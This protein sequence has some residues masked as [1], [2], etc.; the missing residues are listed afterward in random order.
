MAVIVTA[1]VASTPDVVMAN[2][3]V[4]APAAIVIEAGTTALVELDVSVTRAPPAGAGPFRVTVPVGEFPPTKVVGLVVTLAMPEGFTVSVAVADL[5]T[6]VP[7]R[8]T[9]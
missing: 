9:V 5:L 8:V 1:V 2:V 7:V 3:P 6:A 4:V